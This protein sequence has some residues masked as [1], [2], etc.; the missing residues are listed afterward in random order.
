MGVERGGVSNYGRATGLRYFYFL[1]LKTPS[2]TEMMD[3][4]RKCALIRFTF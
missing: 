1:P 4:E 2:E 3:F